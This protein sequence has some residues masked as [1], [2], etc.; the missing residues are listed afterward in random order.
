MNNIGKF[1]IC[2]IM[3]WNLI[4]WFTKYSY[5]RLL[6]CYIKGKH[7]FVINNLFIIEI[8]SKKISIWHS[9]LDFV[10][11]FFVILLNVLCF[12]KI[13][14]LSFGMWFLSPSRYSLASSH[15]PNILYQESM[16]EPFINSFKQWSLFYL[17][18]FELKLLFIN[19]YI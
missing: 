10:V 4:I 6:W 16:F 2:Y 13:S 9:Q 17:K 14:I 11:L 18:E 5:L 15:I 8:V 12:Q 7:R 3:V 19:K 1:K